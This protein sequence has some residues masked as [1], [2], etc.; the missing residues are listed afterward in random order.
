[1]G[2]SV[3]TKAWRQSQSDHPCLSRWTARDGLSMYSVTKIM[4]PAHAN[5][6][7]IPCMFQV[8][9]FVP[10]PCGGIRGRYGPP[11]Q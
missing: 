8:E 10:L 11:V 6:R 4:K 3:S 7:D 2:Q 5:R 1:M 9:V